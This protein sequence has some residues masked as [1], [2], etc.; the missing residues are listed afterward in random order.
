MCAMRALLTPKFQIHL[1]KGGGTILKNLV[2][3]SHQGIQREKVSLFDQTGSDIRF[4]KYGQKYDHFSQMGKNS[5]KTGKFSML[6]ELLTFRS[7][8]VKES[9]LCLPARD[10]G[11]NQ[12]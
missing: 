12:G 11:A 4:T 10:E 2:E 6:S 7:S 8:L 1:V 3:G 9:V 5:A